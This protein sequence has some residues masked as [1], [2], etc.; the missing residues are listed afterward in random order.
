MT[1]I[2]T[3]IDAPELFVIV[4]PDQVPISPHTAWGLYPYTRQEAE[5]IVR[6]NGYYTHYVIE[7]SPAIPAI[8]WLIDHEHLKLPDCLTPFS[9]TDGV[10]LLHTHPEKP[11]MVRF[12]DYNDR[13]KIVT[14]RVGRFLRTRFEHLTD[15]QVAYFSEYFLKGEAPPLE[16][17]AEFEIS[18]DIVGA[19]E[20]G[21]KSC[22]TYSLSDYDTGGVHPCSVYE[23]GEWQIAILRDPEGKIIAR[24]L[25]VPDKKIFFRIYPTANRFQEDGFLSE[26]HAESV[27]MKLRSHLEELG[28]QDMYSLE[29]D[30]LE[31]VQLKY[32]PVPNKDRLVMPYLDHNLCFEVDD[33]NHT[34]Y[35][36]YS[37]Y[38]ADETSGYVSHSFPYCKPCQRN[39][40]GTGT[41]VNN[42]TWV[43]SS[44]MPNT[45]QHEGRTYIC[46][47]AA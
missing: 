24:S 26:D 3:M 16:I 4:H 21:P 17:E 47:E 9:N 44:C 43:C 36:E 22:M 25:I 28:Y 41:F 32:I 1:S 20:N 33:E 8:R 2:N 46:L 19:Y 13:Y 27:R 35:L 42:S 23:N 11:S 14:M 30:D 37:G 6:D 12:V 45:I 15:K 38:R 7:P 18:D 10:Q 34:I 29:P 40:Y 31:G 5:D 39:T